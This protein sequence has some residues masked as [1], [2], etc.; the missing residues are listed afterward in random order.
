M[1]NI[2]SITSL[3]GGVGKTTTAINLAASFA[4]LEKKT[5]IIDCDPQGNVSSGLGINKDAI[6]KDITSVFTGEIN[7][8][9][10]VYNTCLDYLKCI[11]AKF[12]L[13]N[14]EKFIGKNRR[15]PG[16]ILTDKI[17]ALHT[18]YD[19]III[20]TPCAVN[21]L[22]T[23][24]LCASGWALIPVT[25]YLYTIDILEETLANIKKIKDSFNPSL[26]VAGLLLTMYDKRDYISE[27]FSDDIFADFNKLILKTVI[28]YDLKLHEALGS[29]KPVALYDIMAKSAEAHLKLADEIEKIINKSKKKNTYKVIK[30][31]ER[32]NAKID[33]LPAK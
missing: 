5:L 24:A 6:S 7:I 17:R 29:N 26:N 15:N 14:I 8:Q 1:A 9:E 25:Y 22:T 13:Y 19:Y 20:D 3:K 21:F 23:S 31:W 2:I 16:T 27:G 4:V 32:G 10:A 11:P 12:N 30:P 18:I 28:N 33:R